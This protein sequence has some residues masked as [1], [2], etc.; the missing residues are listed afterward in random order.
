MRGRGRRRIDVFAL[1]SSNRRTITVK[2]VSTRSTT[3]NL[4]QEKKTPHRFRAIGLSPPGHGSFIFPEKKERVN[5]VRMS[6][7]R[8]E[9]HDRPRFLKL[10]DESVGKM[11][12]MCAERRLCG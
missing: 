12:R 1:R 6:R 9:R 4:V 11:E 10:L 8:V 3:D 2:T 7:R 5:F